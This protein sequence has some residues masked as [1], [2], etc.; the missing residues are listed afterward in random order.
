M[1]HVHAQIHELT[2]R[3]APIS[4]LPTEVIG[5]ILE[6]NLHSDIMERY[7]ERLPSIVVASHINRRF[8][9]V[10]IGTPTLWTNLDF[11]LMKSPLLDTMLER[12]GTCLVDIYLQHHDPVVFN[13]MRARIIPH[14]G[15]WRVFRI[16]CACL[17]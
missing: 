11:S 14:V 3:L 4:T 1:R 9:E 7:A 12:S 16:Q 6:I 5:A 13:H 10:A 17:S 15:R 2:N 8:L